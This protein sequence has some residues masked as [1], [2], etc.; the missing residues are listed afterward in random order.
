MI[1]VQLRGAT[2]QKEQLLHIIHKKGV[3]VLAAHLDASWRVS[4]RI[5]LICLSSHPCLRDLANTP[6][7]SLHGSYLW[8]GNDSCCLLPEEVFFRHHSKA[9]KSINLQAHFPKENITF[10]PALRFSQLSQN[11]VRCN[12]FENESYCFIFYQTHTDTPTNTEA[13]FY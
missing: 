7:I 6:W 12:S 11:S 1:S 2:L 10:S 9:G 13:Q 4:S 3:K 5:F 8:C